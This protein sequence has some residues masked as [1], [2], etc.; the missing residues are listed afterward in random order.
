MKTEHLKEAL[1]QHPMAIKKLNQ[2]ASRGIILNEW[3]ANEMFLGSRGMGKTYLSYV[4]A[5]ED[6]L[7]RN[8]KTVVKTPQYYDKDVITTSRKAEWFKG[9]RD[10][11][12]A[13]YDKN[14]TV[15]SLSSTS[16]EVVPTKNDERWWL[17]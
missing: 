12:F 15:V 8:E 13:Y 9:F 7:Y 11:L 3:Q 10:F 1:Q 17:L 5:A 2:L 16:I 14:L 4:R 6:I